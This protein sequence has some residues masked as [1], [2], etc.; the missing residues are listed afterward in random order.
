MTTPQSTN[1]QDAQSAV[2][3]VP[4]S[5]VKKN[6]QGDTPKKKK[7]FRHPWIM[8]FMTFPLVGIMGS[9]I[10]PVPELTTAERQQIAQQREKEENEKRLHNN[11]VCMENSLM[12]SIH[13]KKCIIEAEWFREMNKTMQD[14]A[15]QQLK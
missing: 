4:D 3:T 5:P 1:Q 7:M 6:A 12:Y 2:P 8:F 10:N 14:L 13:Q 15:N 9:I 11:R